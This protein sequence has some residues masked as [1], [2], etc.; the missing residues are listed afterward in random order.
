MSPRRKRGA[1]PRARTISARAVDQA[2][3]AHAAEPLAGESRPRTRG[4]CQDGARPCP[5]VGC[6]FNLY[7]DVQETGSI[8]L[9]FPHLEPWEMRESCALDVAD[10]DGTT[11]DL[12]GAMM[13]VSRERVRQ[14]E[15]VIL[16]RVGRAVED[17]ERVA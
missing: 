8:K 5:W 7:L 15:A 9:N 17:G 13:N 12:V 11:L 16:T 6:R 10:R 14:I 3:D 2:V 1:L 4:E